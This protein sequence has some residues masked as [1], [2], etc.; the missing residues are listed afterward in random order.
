MAE[1]FAFLSRLPTPLVEVC[2]FPGHL[3]EP[4][5][6]K[7]CEHGPHSMDIFRMD[8]REKEGARRPCSF[9][10]FR[11]RA[12]CPA[13]HKDRVLAGLENLERAQACATSVGFP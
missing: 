6:R 5:L 10:H 12:F 2:V 8:G 7:V 3:G 4:S 1:V 9:K 11:Q 13:A